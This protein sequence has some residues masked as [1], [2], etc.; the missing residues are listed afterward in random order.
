MKFLPKDY[1]IASIER[2][3]AARRL[4]EQKKYVAA[5]YIAG[6]AVECLL[7]AYMKRKSPHFESRHD[8][9]SLLKESG[10]MD[11][12]RPTDHKKLSACFGE[13]WSRW[14]NN[15]RYA[16]SER[17]TSEY[18][19]LKHYNKKIKGDLLKANSFTIIEN[20][21]MIINKGVARWNSKTN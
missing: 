11:F 14:K 5:I 17:L 16:S 10:L 2:I 12:I 15:Y 3:D 20:A 4:Y 6:V 1:K 19:R 9:Q 21:F 8:L 18:R 7:R 13:V